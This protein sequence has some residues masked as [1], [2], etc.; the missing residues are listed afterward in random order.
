MLHKHWCLLIY[1]IN[2]SEIISPCSGVVKGGGGVGVGSR[3]APPAEFFVSV[4]FFS[5]QH[6]LI[7]SLG[8]DEVASGLI[9]AGST[10]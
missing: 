1:N 8:D 2:T 10:K 7:N 9:E 4:F 6:H 3:R 5:R